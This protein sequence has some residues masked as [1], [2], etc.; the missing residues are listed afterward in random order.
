[1]VETILCS[2]L[3]ELILL[4]FKCLENP[5]HRRAFLLT[6]HYVYKA[7][8]SHERK[9]FINIPKYIDPTTSISFFNWVRRFHPR[10]ERNNSKFK[11]DPDL[12]L[13]DLTKS[14]NL[15]LI[16]YTVEQL[17]WKI[18]KGALYRTTSLPCLQYLSQLPNFMWRFEYTEYASEHGS[19][20]CLQ[21]ALEKGCPL[22]RKSFQ[23]AAFGGH[24][25]IIQYIR[26]KGYNWGRDIFE[27]AVKS[28]NLKLVQYLFQNGCPH[29]RMDLCYASASSHLNILLYLQEIGYSLDESCLY[30][31]AYGGHLEVV[32]YLH[33]QNCSWNTWTYQGAA[34][35]GHLEILK[36]LH[37]NGFPWDEETFK[38][39]VVNDRLNVLDYLNQ[40]G[41]PWDEL[42]CKKIAK[43]HGYSRIV[44]WIEKHNKNA[45]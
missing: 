43:V 19:L 2:L 4:I 9:D 44:E 34:E 6:C 37:E 15:E 35:G 24:L 42:Y 36:Y 23:L 26:E 40:H 38:S 27:S 21:Y 29:S 16:K 7:V 25:E 17:N 41:C 12:R 5:I 31:A 33:Q 45:I 20:D 32:Q 14:N 1:M 39:A 8:P 18:H 28:G 3:P 22:G 30:M 10:F 11:D 13:F